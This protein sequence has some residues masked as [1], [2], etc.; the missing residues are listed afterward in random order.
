MVEK[1]PKA[2]AQPTKFHPYLYSI[3]PLHSQ[4]HIKQ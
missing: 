2:A 3:P 4:S 1:P